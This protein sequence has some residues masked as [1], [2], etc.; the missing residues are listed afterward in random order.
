MARESILAVLGRITD[1]N[2]YYHF[3]IPRADDSH[4]GRIL[5]YV[6]PDSNGFSIRVPLYSKL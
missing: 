5:R 3:L 2:C 1:T 4:S 6:V